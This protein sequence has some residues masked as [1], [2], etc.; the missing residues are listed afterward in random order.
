MIDN[1]ISENTFRIIKYIA[2]YFKIQ[3]TRIR[4]TFNA[5]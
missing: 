2:K 5:I 1:E 3:K 4:M